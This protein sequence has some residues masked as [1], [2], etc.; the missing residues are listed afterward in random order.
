MELRG[1]SQTQLA[2]KLDVSSA[3]ISD[4][5]SGKK[6]PRPARLEQLAEV[7]QVTVTELLSVDGVRKASDRD[8][9]TF[10][11]ENPDVEN[12]V[13]LAIQ[14]SPEDRALLIPLMRRLLYGD[15]I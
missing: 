14:L 12:I 5:C 7:L 11:K 6:F 8:Q 3:T 1:I 9:L 2:L 15:D 10:I 13:R 4:W